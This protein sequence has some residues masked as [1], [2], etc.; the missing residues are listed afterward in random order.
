MSRL[1]TAVG[2]LIVVLGATAASNG[3]QP[4]GPYQPRPTLSPWLNMFR[5]DTGP[6]DNYHTFVQPRF[7][8]QQA[9]QAQQGAIDQQQ[10]NIDSLGHDVTQ[11]EAQRHAQIHPTGTASTYMNFSHYYGAQGGAG[12]AARPPAA[13]HQA[14]APRA[15]THG[16]A[17]M[18]RTGAF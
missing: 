10:F 9:F 4:Y 2:A 14:A 3:Q 12:H 18:P 1:L 16:A 15:T 5:R 17:A 13:A 6:L 8:A 7:Q 11:L